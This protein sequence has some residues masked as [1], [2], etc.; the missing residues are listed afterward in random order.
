MPDLEVRHGTPS[1]TWKNHTHPLPKIWELVFNCFFF[2][3]CFRGKLFFSSSSGAWQHAA[4]ARGRWRAACSQGSMEGSGESGCTARWCR[5]YKETHHVRSQGAPKT[6][7]LIPSG[8]KDFFNTSG[9]KDFINPGLKVF[10]K[11]V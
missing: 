2:S 8:L 7:L 11:M 9:L 6:P 1:L 10:I 4:T 5:H 3:T